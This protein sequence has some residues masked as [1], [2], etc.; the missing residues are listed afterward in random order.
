[1]KNQKGFT[2]TEL[3]IT[4]SIASIVILG[5]NSLLLAIASQ[6][7]K[8]EQKLN[9]QEFLRSA[10][11]T[12]ETDSECD[13]SLKGLNVSLGHPIE[14]QS[15]NTNVEIVRSDKIA[16][17][18]TLARIKPKTLGRAMKIGNQ[19][20]FRQILQVEFRLVAKPLRPPT[21]TENGEQ[22]QIMTSRFSEIPIVTTEITGGT[23]VSCKS[24]NSAAFACIS[25]GWVWEP[26]VGCHARPTNTCLYFGNYTMSKTS[27]QA[28]IPNGSTGK[29]SCPDNSTAAITGQTN[30]TITY[31]CMSCT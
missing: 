29:A 26:N 21:G 14:F 28:I 3:F 31:T 10:V 7:I 13:R 11:R 24:E 27:G 17:L 8:S 6:Q 20:L 25:M 4:V 18:S 9:A 1:M 19:E 23:I 2:L 12:L 30:E 15:K 22:N 16:K 5:L